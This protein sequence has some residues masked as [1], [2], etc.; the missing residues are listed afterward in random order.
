MTGE[1]GA[2]HRISYRHHKIL[3]KIAYL[4]LIIVAGFTVVI[5]LVLLHETHQT[6]IAKTDRHI[7][8]LSASVSNSL[9]Q[10]FQRT[11]RI[12]ESVELSYDQD[13]IL[14][15]TELERLHERADLLQ[16]EYF[17][18][19]SPDGSAVCSDGV[20]R[21]F[22]QQAG[23]MKA[24]EGQAVIDVESSKTETDEQILNM[25]F[26]AIP[27]RSH[28]GTGEITGIFA[29]PVSPEQEDFYLV[30]SYYGGNVFFNLVKPDGTEIFMTTHSHVLPVD[31]PQNSD[32]QHNL[33]DTL[34]A[35]VEII[36]DTSVDDLREAAVSGRN[37]TIRFHLPNSSS[38]QT[39]Q[40]SPISDTG[41][42][43]WMVDTDDAVSEGIDQI[44]HIAF[45]I[46]GLGVVCFCLIITILLFLYRKN[47]HILM[48]DPVTG[49][50]SLSRFTQEAE[51]LVRHSNPGEYTLIVMNIVHFKYFNDTYGSDESNRILKYV[52]TAIQKYMED[53]EILVRSGADDF[54][55]LIRTSRNSNEVIIQKLELMVDE[56]NRFN[57]ELPK[58][59][60]IMFR[61]G[62]YQITD[63]SLSVIHMSDRANIARKKPKIPVGD[64]LYSCGFY[65]EEDLAQLQKE[66]ILVNKMNDAL[67]NHDFKM[68]LQPKVDISTG[69]IVA[70]EAL[71]RW[72]NP[73]MGLVRPDEFIPLFERNG[74]IRKL[75][76]YMFEQVCACLRRWLDEGLQPVQISINL[77]RV[78]LANKDFLKPFIAVQEKYRIPPELLEFELLESALQEFPK[79][80]PEAV[81]QIHLAGY[82]C[83]LDDFGS[84]YSS[85]NNLESLDIDVVKLDRE[86]LNT[87]HTEG[88]RGHIVIEELIH[89]ARR[90]GITVCCE[91][92]ETVEQLAFLQ[93]CHCDKGQGYLFSKPVEV[94]VFEEM[95]FGNS[96]IK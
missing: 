66:N 13:G 5:N 32:K 92:V 61:V 85:L 83:S 87:A 82:T 75:D 45:R 58:K 15:S 54:N 88:D 19:I 67:E 2:A 68:Y 63:T 4:V 14:S 16:F 26:F 69:K 48:V 53:G 62:V 22:S 81:C 51:R 34:D 95:L 18:F 41:L 25:P 27:I 71:V 46:N 86:F 79:A 35:N 76:L 1:K 94:S 28:G 38:T 24:F 65:E 77:S 96:Q 91:G 42:C 52:H 78:H 31:E 3:V 37:A 12:L 8:E 73:D 74:F 64:I 55:L 9:A 39:G 40:L 7:S 17:A 49:G 23:I 89:M 21:T 36:R 10:R 59:E 43:V 84:G 47:T 20:S 93:K 70:A 72:Q 80:L 44:L 57:K 30:Q 29:A 33:F 56:V 60:W 90:L 50:Y 6:I 11:L